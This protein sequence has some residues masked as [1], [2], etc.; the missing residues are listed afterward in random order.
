[1]T[2][3][4][5]FNKADMYK[6]K[7]DESKP[8]NSEQLIELDNYFRV[9]FTY[10]SNSIEGNTLTITETKL[11]LEDG[12]TVGGKPIN[13][14]YEAAGHAEAY[15]YMLDQ[16]RSEEL[17]ITEDIIKQLH[18]LFYNKMDKDEAG[19]YRKIQ[20]YISGTEYLPPVPEEVPQLMEHFINQMESSRR[21]LHPIEFAAI[22]HKRL[23]DIQPFKDGNRR[24]ARLLMNLILVNSGYGI[25]EVP[26]VLR[27][28]YINSL[29]L[30][31][32]EINPDFDIFIKFIAECVVETE[33]DYC[34]LLRIQ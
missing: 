20:V 34:R 1:M 2:K 19:K 18:Y 24:T 33:R 29:M 3:K 6:N 9:G 10:S 14:Y 13:D 23:V 8:F 27:N 17:K 7:I 28:E 21:F 11:L 12:I 31:Q 32:R 4:E 25:T 16:A 5:L 30:S 26:P 22:C 15:D